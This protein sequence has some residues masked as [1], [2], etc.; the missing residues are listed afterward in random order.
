MASIHT[1]PNGRRRILFNSP[2]GAR[3]CVRLG[4]VP[5]RV[6]E[7][8][9]TR[10]E[11]IVGCQANNV[12]IDA[13]TAKWLAEIKDDRLYNRMVKA[14]LTQERLA[15]GRSAHL[16]GDFLVKYIASRGDIKPGTR[17]NFEQTQRWLLS[18]FGPDKPLS[19]ISPGDAEE[20]RTHFIKEGLAEPTLRRHLKRAGQFFLHAKRKRFIAENPFEGMKGLTVRGNRDKFYF[21]TREITEK[22]MDACP[23]A[24]WRLII[25]LSRFGGLRCPSEHM[26]LKWTDVDW[27]K[28]RMT[29]RSPKTERHEGKD[30]RVIPL[31]PELRS[32]LKDCFDPSNTYVI[33]D[34][35][36]QGGRERN[37]RTM[38]LKIIARAGLKPWP[39][40][41]HNLRATRQTELAQQF[42]QHVVSEWLGNSESV[43]VEHYLRTLD[44]D[45]TRAITPTP[46]PSQNPS[47]STAV[48]PSNTQETKTAPSLQ[49]EAVP[50]VT[51]SCSSV[52]DDSMTLGRFE[53]PFWP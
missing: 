3:R 49:D 41:F 53:P 1:E 4:K 10:I 14:G 2:D 22:L 47:Q 7:N 23:D 43:A 5:V 34:H 21:V 26:E 51:S 15:R 40:L 24:E 17:V 33:T 19:S 18:Y 35:R 42:P 38:M 48:L 16:L 12:S 32:A 13:E 9:K 39:K 20:L 50:Y 11:L 45:F 31:F 46:N 25:A 37:F 44:D 36:G 6:A 29:V 52:Q 30:K 28:G 27:E 8:F